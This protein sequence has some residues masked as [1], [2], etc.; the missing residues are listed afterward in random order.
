MHV[1]IPVNLHTHTILL[2]FFAALHVVKLCYPL[3]LYTCWPCQ[4][5][6]HRNL[7]PVF[8]RRT[9]THV[10]AS[11]TRLNQKHKPPTTPHNT[12]ISLSIFP[13][14]SSFSCPETKNTM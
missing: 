3:P 12:E 4:P 9:E 8:P 6:A 5:D 14:F 10:F 13:A 2:M 11:C 7:T 1:N